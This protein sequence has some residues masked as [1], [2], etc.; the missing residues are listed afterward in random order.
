MLNNGDPETHLW[1]NCDPF[2]F[3]LRA[4]ANRGCQLR[5]GNEPVQ[6]TTRYYISK[7]GAPLTVERPPPK[8]FEAGWPKRASGVS[9]AHY[10]R[11][12][13]ANGFQW[14][15]TV[16]TKNH[17]VYERTKGNLQ[18]GWNVRECNRAVAFDWNDLNRDWYLAEAR[19]LM[20]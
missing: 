16:C 17:S 9:E 4:K 6:R 18:S 7:S 10:M 8:G 11:V 20:V 13:Q 3:M 1:G 2:D 19:K 12:M 14:D 15:A 5:I